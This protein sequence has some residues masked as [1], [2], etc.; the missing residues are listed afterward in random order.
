[1]VVE[2]AL[3]QPLWSTLKQKVNKCDIVQ[4]LAGDDMCYLLDPNN[5]EVVKVKESKLTIAGR[6]E[7]PMIVS[8]SIWI[9]IVYGWFAMAWKLCI[10]YVP[11]FFSW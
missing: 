1:M 8:S 3:D 5:K 6:K 2:E 10:K 7:E 11:A 4:D 9:L